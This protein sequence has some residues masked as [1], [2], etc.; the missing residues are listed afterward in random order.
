LD[1]RNRIQ[2]SFFAAAFL[3]SA[4]FTAAEN[5]GTKEELDLIDSIG[6]T[7]EQAY[8]N[9]G[10]PEEV[11]PYRGEKAW[12]DTVVF[13]FDEHLYLFWYENRVWQVRADRRYGKKFRGITMGMHKE[14]LEDLLGQP[15][16]SDEASAIYR[17]PDRGYPLRMRLFFDN[18]TLSDLYI[19][20]SDF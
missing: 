1:S 10:V 17:L 18:G 13:Y 3:L 9:L 20:R 7:L 2:V 14:E 11:F 8:T 16:Q 12:Q 6:W 5:P 19:Y 4:A 15:Y